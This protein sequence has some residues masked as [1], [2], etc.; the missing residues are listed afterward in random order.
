MIFAA[1]LSLLIF[2]NS[3][4]TGNFRQFPATINP[5]GLSRVTPLAM[6]S[7][8]PAEASGFGR[9]KLQIVQAGIRATGFQQFDMGAGFNNAPLVENDDQVGVLNG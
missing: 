6:E 3:G 7:C 5:F 9:L 4:H 2:S 1:L 8:A